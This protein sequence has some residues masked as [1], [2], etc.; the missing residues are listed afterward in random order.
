MTSNVE[1]DRETA[2]SCPDVPAGSYVVLVVNDTGCG[3]T[4]EVRAKIFEP[5]FT[6]KSVGKGTG[7]GLTV[8]HEIVKQCGGHIAVLSEPGAG[9]TFQIYFPAAR[10]RS[11][12][13][14]PLRE[15]CSARGSETVLLVEDEEAL[16]RF[17]SAALESYGYNVLTAAN[18]EDA[19]RLVESNGGRIDLLL[20]DVVMPGMSGCDLAL[21]LRQRWPDL[22]VL[23]LSGYTE[24]A[25]MHR[26]TVAR[27]TF[28]SK[29]FSPAALATKVRQILDQGRTK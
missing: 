11:I 12:R 23:L 6:T 27:A 5:F 4:A 14:S 28:L 18:G 10:G 20:T 9:T 3:M 13:T 1:L 19:L 22:R 16:R 29:P 17:G 15:K 21:A 7:L 25:I 26:G 24:E 2:K 8:V